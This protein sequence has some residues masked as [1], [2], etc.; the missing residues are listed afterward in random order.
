MQ[1]CLTGMGP[2][3]GPAMAGPGMPAGPQP[4]GAP[5]PPPPMP[6]VGGGMDPAQNNAP[7]QFNTNK[8]K[9]PMPIAGTGKTTPPLPPRP[10]NDSQGDRGKQERFLYHAY[11]KR[12]ICFLNFI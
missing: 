11:D 12:N 10:R 7:L 6:P 8:G 9:P 2:G 1:Q 4:M 3:M 5:L